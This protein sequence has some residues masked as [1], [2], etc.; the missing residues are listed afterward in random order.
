M[1]QLCGTATVTATPGGGTMTLA[2]A[3]RARM[4][5]AKDTGVGMG[6]KKVS[7]EPRSYA[8]LTLQLASNQ[9]KVSAEKHHQVAPYGVSFSSMS[10]EVCREK[11]EKRI[12]LV[13]VVA[14]VPRD[15]PRAGRWW[16]PTVGRPVRVVSPALHCQHSPL[17][18]PRDTPPPPAIA[19]S[20]PP[21]PPLCVWLPFSTTCLPCD[22]RPARL[23]VA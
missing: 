12:V 9:G 22:D 6:E 10:L 2:Q 20:P 15:V 3:S 21:P 7:E 17:P 23:R 16:R 4:L 8:K 13:L 1:S 18:S 14:A 11:K 19:S 5:T